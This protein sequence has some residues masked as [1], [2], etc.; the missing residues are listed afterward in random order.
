LNDNIFAGF[1][2]QKTILPETTETETKFLT[3]G[4]R[5]MFLSTLAFA[6]ANVF[7]KKVA[8]IP[9]ME[10]VFFA[11]PPEFYTAMSGSEK[12]TPT[13]AAQTA[14][15]SRCADFSARPRSFC[16]S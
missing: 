5:A 4:V 12:Q 6:L 16:F 11:A 15:C 14:N 3:E 1:S 10:I 8:H 7:V 13:G 2:K 9:V